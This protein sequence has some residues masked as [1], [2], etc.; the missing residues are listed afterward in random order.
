MCVFSLFLACFEPLL[1][2]WSRVIDV[3]PPPPPEGEK[4]RSGQNE[5]SICNSNKMRYGRPGRNLHW[6]VKFL[7]SRAHTVTLCVC[8]PRVTFTIQRFSIFYSKVVELS[9]LAQVDRIW[10]FFTSSSTQSFKNTKRKGYIIRLVVP[11]ADF[12]FVFYDFINEKY[13][14]SSQ[15]RTLVF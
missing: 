4:A 8:S 3:T 1:H 5:N 2:F 7:S 15:T 6:N 10:T 9:Y 13:P 11:F 14:A 12:S